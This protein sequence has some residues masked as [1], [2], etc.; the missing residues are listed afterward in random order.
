M[1]MQTNPF[2][3]KN[4][5]CLY[6]KAAQKWWFSAVDICAILTDSDYESAREYW[7]AS[8]YNFAVKGNQLV[9]SCDQLKMPARNGKYY[10]TEV[11][12]IRQVIY[13]IQIIPSPKA[14]PYRLW[15]A[16]M[17]ASN[18]PMEQ[19]LSEAGEPCAAQI[20]EEYKNNPHKLF[21]RLSITKEKLL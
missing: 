12:D 21:E 5:R 19:L 1:K 17:V 8:K 3:N 18:T 7:K 14:E 13:L 2:A 15:L 4:L 10:F 20:Q 9:A 16:D 6:D 11:L